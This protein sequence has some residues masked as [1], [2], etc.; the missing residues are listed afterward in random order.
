MS[1]QNIRT[2][3]TEVK[4]GETIGT[5]L[6][7]TV[8]VDDLSLPSPQ[9][10]KEYNAINPKLVEFLLEQT[11]KEQEHRHRLDNQ[12]MKILAKSEGRTFRINWW[13]MFFAFLALIALLAL[14]AFALYL[15]L[16]WIA[17]ILGGTTI[18]TI[19]S[20]FVTGTKNIDKK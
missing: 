2:T 13:G 12:K 10:L 17:G 14:A 16:P 7:Q 15:D 9:E 1:K 4:A 6:E 18:F 20:L 19:V 5:Q 3:H 8:L 11:K